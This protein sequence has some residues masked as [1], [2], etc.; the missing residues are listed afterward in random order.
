MR[1]QKAVER[2]SS[3][4]SA[5]LVTMFQQKVAVPVAQPNIINFSL[6]KLQMQP[7]SSGDW[8]NSS[9]KKHFQ[10]ADFLFSIRGG[11][12]VCRKW[13]PWSP[14]PHQRHRQKYLSCSTTCE[15]EI[16]YCSIFFIITDELGFGKMCAKWISRLFTPEQ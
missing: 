14:T 2:H 5:S 10:E 3:F 9:R 11:L 13:K 16:S 1:V 8:L 12:W 4:P 15:I 6:R 7:K